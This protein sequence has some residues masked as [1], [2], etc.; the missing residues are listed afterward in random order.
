VAK[1]VGGLR[2]MGHD[3]HAAVLRAPR[4]AQEVHLLTASELYDGINNG[5]QL[6][7]RLLGR[8]VSVGPGGSAKA[9][10]IQS[11]DIEAL[12]GQDVHET[13]RRFP[14]HLEVKALPASHS[15]AVG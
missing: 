7:T 15:R 5:V 8:H 3:K 12:P 1:V 9:P 13:I 11:K 10:D 2:G 14:G 6:L 4:P